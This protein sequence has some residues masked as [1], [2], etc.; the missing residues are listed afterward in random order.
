M[1][2]YAEFSMS[3]EDFSSA[4]A[5]IKNRYVGKTIETVPTETLTQKDIPFDSANLAGKKYI[6]H[7]RLRRPAGR[8]YAGTTLRGTAYAINP[9]VAGQTDDAE[10]EPTSYLLSENVSYDLLRAAK[11]DEMAFKAAMDLVTFGMRETSAYDQEVFNLYGN[12]HVG[13]LDTTN[14]DG[15]GAAVDGG[16]TYTVTITKATWAAGLFVQ[17]EGGYY[18]VY[19]SLGTGAKLNANQPL[20]LTSVDADTRT[21][22]LTGNAADIDDIHAGTTPALIPMNAKGEWGW[23]I[24]Q[25]LSASSGLLFGLSTDYA[26]WKAVQHAIT[27]KAAVQTFSDLSTKKLIR[28]GGGDVIVYSSPWTFT[29]LNNDSMELKRDVRAKGGS[30]EYGNNEIVIVGAGGRMTIR[31]HT[32]VMAGYAYGLTLGT[33]KRVGTTDHTWS[34]GEDGKVIFD[35]PSNAGKQL[36]CGWDC[37]PFCSEPAKNFVLSGIENHSLG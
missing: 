6:R 11:N 19:A 4:E 2:D 35:L 3:D 22:V 9:P 10:V 18:D 13:A 7:V 30:V 29:D 8:T 20:Q 5:I 23:G 24:H 26:T 17:A 16:T 27:G 15:G 21:I 34:P 37:T 14:A 12:H 36:R 33:W 32:M 1:P 28:G 25:I 31:P